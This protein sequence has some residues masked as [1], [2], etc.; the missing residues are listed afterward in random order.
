MENCIFCKII[1][2][3]IGAAKVWE[4]DNFLAVLDINPNTKGMTLV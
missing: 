3:E 1:K 2:G 4:D